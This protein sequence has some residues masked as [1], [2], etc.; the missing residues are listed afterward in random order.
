MYLCFRES[1]GNRQEDT[2][3]TCKEIP[4]EIAQMDLL[5]TRRISAQ[6]HTGLKLTEC[7]KL[8]EVEGCGTCG[9]HEIG[10]SAIGE[11]KGRINEKIP[12]HFQRALT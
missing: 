2:H 1:K 12:I 11:L 6:N 7:L 9:V 10:R 5:N 8:D 3:N 4:L